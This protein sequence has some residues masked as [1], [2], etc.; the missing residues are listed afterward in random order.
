MDGVVI[1]VLCDYVL[2]DVV[3]RYNQ[4]ECEIF[5]VEFGVVFQ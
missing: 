2:V 4:V 3:F 1:E 5:D